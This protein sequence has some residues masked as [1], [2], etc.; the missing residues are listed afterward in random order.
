MDAN[1]LIKAV[2]AE[3]VKEVYSDTVSDTLKEASKIGVDLVKTLRLALFP[4]QYGALLQDRLARH[5]RKSIERVPSERRVVPVESLSLQIAEKL[6]LQEDGSLLTEMYVNLLARAMDK[7]RV[8]EAHPAFVQII[9]QLAPDEALLMEQLSS[10]TPSAYVRWK[11][12]DDVMGWSDREAAVLQA[13]C[14]DDSRQL[15]SA[16]VVRPE[17]LQQSSLLH[18]YIEH[19]VSLGLVI[20]TF[21]HQWA[22][23]FG[24]VQ[25]SMP[26]V[27]IHFICLTRFGGLF[28]RA[29]L[30]DGLS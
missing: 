4:I 19:L 10:N 17:A 16:I 15:L 9:G 28:H 22:S 6:R 26:G 5:L 21:E 20:Y 27:E 1:D 23:K 2:P 11:S 30:G 24:T 25:T 8:S 3:V 12:S 29:C 18:T 14:A 7:E 13:Q